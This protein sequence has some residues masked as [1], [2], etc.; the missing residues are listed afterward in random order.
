MA[1]W[2]AKYINSLPDSAFAVIEPAYKAGKFNNKS[3]RHLP[4]FNDRGEI[5]L[6]HLRNALARWNQIKAVSKSI[7]TE[8]LRTRALR[9]LATLK[10]KYL[11]DEE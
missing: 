7:S 1:R 10:K 3:A 11:G 9:K 4:V 8:E 2:T 5:D 6:P